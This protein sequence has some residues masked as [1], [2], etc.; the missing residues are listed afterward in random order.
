MSELKERLKQLGV[1]E[2]VGT[3]T[4]SSGRAIKTR[5]SV[6]GNAKVNEKGRT[7]STIYS[8]PSNIKE[9]NTKENT[10]ILSAYLAKVR[11][12]E[13]DGDS[14]VIT[15]PQEVISIIDNM[16]SF[17]KASKTDTVR[18]L[19]YAG[20]SG[21]TF[22][23]SVYSDFTQG[24]ITAKQA[25]EMLNKKG[26][27][28]EYLRGIDDIRDERKQLVSRLKEV[29]RQ[30]RVV[31]ETDARRSN[32]RAER[33]SYQMPSE[34]TQA[35]RDFKAEPT[36]EGNSI[37]KNAMNFV[38]IQANNK[39]KVYNPQKALLGIY[40]DLDGAKR[41]VQREEPKQR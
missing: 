2:V 23:K 28:Y 16:D 37:F 40:T 29:V 9:L 1:K 11:R 34:Q 8:E 26:D 10:D 5:M 20:S 19:E 15:V 21:S 25:V 3:I 24:K 35:W 17:T 27:V 39:Y 7:V 4:D 13:R 36:T 14:S 41:R 38:I 31:S 12:A 18:A 22:A 6:F 30:K 33:N 32:T